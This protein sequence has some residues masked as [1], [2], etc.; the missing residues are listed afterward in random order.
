MGKSPLA[1]PIAPF[2]SR[3][4]VADDAEGVRE[5]DQILSQLP[6]G[7]RTGVQRLL[8]AVSERFNPHDGFIDAVIVWENLFGAAGETRLR[9]CGALA[10]VLHPDDAEARASFFSGAQKLYDDRS[11][12]V[13]GNDKKRFTI[14]EA[15]ER[16]NKSVHIAIGAT[17]AVMR[18]D[19]LRGAKDSIERGRLVVINGAR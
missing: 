5:W 6:T 18:S 12:L 8:S 9:V 16:R 15:T 11:V 7:M 1:W 17:R 14:T 4:L 13:H 2:Q 10:W 19:Q 3:Q